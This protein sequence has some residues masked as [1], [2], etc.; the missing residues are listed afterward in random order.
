MSREQQK[1]REEW[2]RQE[3][4]REK[5]LHEKEKAEAQ[6]LESKG[7][8]ISF[9]IREAA[10]QGKPLQDKWTI[11]G[12]SG[13]AW[14]DNDMPVAGKNI[15]GVLWTAMPASVLAGGAHMVIKNPDGADSVVG[16]LG[17]MNVKVA[18]MHVGFGGV[19]GGVL[20]GISKVADRETRLYFKYGGKSL[21]LR[22][23]HP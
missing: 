9:V 4:L 7:V 1:M 13:S 17:A 6:N 16:G 2:K 11:G 10:R 5:I 23:A 15:D 19:L 22:V 12:D 20:T 21:N 14:L 18:G 8:P 3:A